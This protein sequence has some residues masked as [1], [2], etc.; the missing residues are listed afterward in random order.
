M[1]L[2]CCKLGS[3]GAT[4]IVLNVY[5]YYYIFCGMFVEALMTQMSCHESRWL[6]FILKDESSATQSRGTPLRKRTLA[7]QLTAGSEVVCL[8]CC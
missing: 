4:S 5:Q 8:P 1:Y 7:K 6:T 3:F 2:A